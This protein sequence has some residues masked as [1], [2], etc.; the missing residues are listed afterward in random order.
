M[1]LDEL[2]AI[3]D[4]GT[5]ETEYLDDIRLTRHNLKIGN[6]PLR[7]MGADEDFD[8][9]YGVR[10]AESREADAERMLR[11]LRAGADAEAAQ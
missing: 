7:V 6:V 8:D 11:L 3:A 1:K 2:K 4:E 10:I 5:F 9:V